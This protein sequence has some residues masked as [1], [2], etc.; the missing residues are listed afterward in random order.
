VKLTLKEFKEQILPDMQTKHS[1]RKALED[2]VKAFFKDNEIA[3]DDGERIEEVVV[4]DILGPA[5]TKATDDGKIDTKAIVDQVT[6]NV[7]DML[8]KSAAKDKRISSAN[9]IP[10]TLPA[11]VKSWGS[12]KNWSGKDADRNC[13]LFGQWI[14][15]QVFGQETGVAACKKYG[16]DIAPIHV[17]AQYENI[18]AQGGFLVPEQF[19][20]G[21][22][23]LIEQYGTFRKN[24]ELV[25]MTGDT[26][27][28]PRYT[29]GLTAS[30]VGEGVA[31]TVTTAT[32]D[33]VKLIAKKLMVL[34]ATS[35]ELN[36][37]A[38]MNIGDYLAGRAAWAIAYKEDLCGWN[39]DGTSTYGGILGF[40]AAIKKQVTDLS[41]TWATDAHKLYASSVVQAA[42]TTWAAITLA[43]FNTVIGKLPQYAFAM[44]GGPKWYCSRQFYASVMQRLAVALAVDPANVYSLAA[45]PSFLGIPVEFAQVLPVV[46]ATETI[47]VWLANLPLSAMFGDRR[48]LRI[49][50]SD[51]VY[52]TS[53]QLALKA[54]ERFDINVHDIGNASATA[55]SLV[56][57]PVACMAILHS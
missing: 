15:G 5:D 37:D 32:F 9:D 8:A 54:T 51:Q 47:P 2:A 18:N 7:G 14:R 30:F 28:K 6:K 41:G 44:G 57:G 52:F 23:M 11:N 50:M 49:G 4:A 22:I 29:G 1:E 10:E 12:I 20:P 16:I 26:A 33:N 48:E 17:K 24:A 36:E 53:D 31:G 45:T 39:G 27:I 19:L 3:D 34:A 21:L 40:D 56:P 46:T 38:V 25:P 43:N 35:T 55:A 13:Y 42:G